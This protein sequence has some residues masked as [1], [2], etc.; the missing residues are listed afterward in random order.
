[1]TD[2][3][4]TLEA[5]RVA[6]AM[7]AVYENK[8]M[9][10]KNDISGDFSSDNASYPT[11]KA[12]K[13]RY[14]D[15][16]STVKNGHS[17]GNITN[18][19]AIGNV[20]GKIITTGSNG[21]LQAVATLETTDVL[22]ATALDKIG[23]NANASQH[24]INQIVNNLLKIAVSQ[25]GT[26]NLGMASTYQLTQNGVLI[27]EIDIPKDFLLQSASVETVGSSPSTLEN[28]NNLDTGDSY[29]KLVVNT[30]NSESGVTPLVIPISNLFD[31]NNA[32]ETSLT[33]SNNIF[34]IK[35]GGVTVTHLA[36]NAVETAKIKDGNVTYAKLHTDCI[37]SLKDDMQD[38]I[39]L[40]CTALANA[41][42][43]SS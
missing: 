12:V 1:M 35:A 39:G 20:S 30:S 15:S 43:P 41:I 21:I 4:Y 8:Q 38:E 19:G 42:N 32:D 33:E 34:S 10:K 28:A 3:D 25:K 40:F 17:H 24:A 14:E 36:N 9:N 2:N 5:A 13:E 37:N 6:S 16:T 11:V 7:D 22:E 23:T 18:G 27:G 29:I 26:A 31:L